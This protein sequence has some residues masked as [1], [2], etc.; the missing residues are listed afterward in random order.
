MDLCEFENS[1]V[2]CV[3]AHVDGW[4]TSSTGLPV[5]CFLGDVILTTATKNLKIVLVCISPIAGAAE[6]F[7]KYTPVL[8]IPSFESCLLSLFDLVSTRS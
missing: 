3:N 5:A 6:S 4:S 7:L 1:L 2:P 8:Y